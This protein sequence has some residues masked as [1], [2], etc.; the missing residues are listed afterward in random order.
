MRGLRLMG[1]LQVV[2]RKSLTKLSGTTNFFVMTKIDVQKR[3]SKLRLHE[4]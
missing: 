2:T 3:Y 1:R 4:D